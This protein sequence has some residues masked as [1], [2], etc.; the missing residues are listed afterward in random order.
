MQRKKLIAGNWKLNMTQ[1][2]TVAY[3]NEFK[4]KINTNSGTEVYLC[5]SFTSLQIA[6]QTSEATSIRV[7]AQDI[8]QFDNGAYTGEIS[9]EM[10][11]EI[12][13]DTVLVG[14]SERREIFKEDDSIINAK[15]IQALKN[16]LRVILCCGESD[17]I[18]SEN[19]TDEWIKAQISSGLQ[20]ISADSLANIVIAYE[21]IWAIG[22]GK[23]C[24]SV[25][26]NRVI[27]MIRDHLAT[28]YSKDLAD[29][30]QILYGGSVKSS[31]AAELL[32][33]SDIDGALVGGA[34]L[35]AEEFSLIV[36]AAAVAL[37]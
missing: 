5:P 14:H 11:K 17:A 8:S 13:V 22:T 15:T 23:T 16:S 37:R 9:A 25:E 29:K 18:R 1:A 27:K 36:N 7:S 21:P 6:K 28:L 24:D 32:S 2:Q 30:M 33:Q 19:K 20:N 12:G 26:A 10:L 3:I 35:K 4:T 34:S 31:N